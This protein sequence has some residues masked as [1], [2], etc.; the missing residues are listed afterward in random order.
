MTAPVAFITVLYMVNELIW[1]ATTSCVMVIELIEN[2]FMASGK[3]PPKSRM[4]PVR[5]SA[6]QTSVFVI[7]VDNESDMRTVLFTNIVEKRAEFAETIG[8]VVV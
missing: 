2:S 5:F 4:F 1:P 6:T 8:T 3:S 7:A